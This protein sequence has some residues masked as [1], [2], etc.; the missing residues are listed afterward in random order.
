MRVFSELSSRSFRVS[1]AAL[2]LA[3]AVVFG[4][5]P[6]P[7]QTGALDAGT[8]FLLDRQDADGGWTSAQVRGVQATTEAV[9]ALQETARGAAARAAAAD[10]LGTVPIVDNDD[11]ARR[12]EAL[13][14]EGRS[15]AAPLGE[16]LAQALATG[17]WGLTPGFD[18][19]SL[20]LPSRRRHRPNPAP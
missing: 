11:R 20:P 18:A 12:F 1:L 13:A 6:S 3:V 4:A 10:L 15:V 14:V 19:G 2:A 7:A 5:S 9:R 16:L 17:G 8:G